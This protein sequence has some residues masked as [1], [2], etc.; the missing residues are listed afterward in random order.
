MLTAFV[1]V[2]S[3]A[4]TPDLKACDRDTAV[5]L[6]RLPEQVAVPGTCL[7]LGSAYL[8][9]TNIGSTLSSDERVKIVCV[10]TRKLYAGKV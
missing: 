1:L 9:Q 7:K 5:H 6:Y 2:C 4:L 10:P 8:A 3:L